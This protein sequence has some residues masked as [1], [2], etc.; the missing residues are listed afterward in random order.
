MRLTVG[1]LPPAVYWRRRAIVLSG[2]LLV[3]YVAAQACMAGSASPENASS[4][5]PS[6]S[7][8]PP[9]T[10]QH[11]TP[12]AVPLSQPPPPA[13][14]PTAAPTTEPAATPVDPNACTDD[15]MLITAEAAQAEITSGASVRFTIRIRND[16]DRTCSRDI[17]GDLRELYL[18]AGEGGGKVWSSRDC[19]PPDGTEVQE[20]TPGYEREHWLDWTGRASD[21][22]D[23]GQPGGELVP[24]GGYELVARLGTAYSE[25]VAI[26]VVPAA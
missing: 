1:P 11:T 26:T 22:C 8:S 14:T 7:P 10:V 13:A 16:S 4:T 24:P 5:G 15:E 12:P 19:N 9:R 21:S 23:D 20:L 25:P 6:D 18:R 17:G 3:L 2:V